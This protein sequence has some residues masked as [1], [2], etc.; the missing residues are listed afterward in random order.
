MMTTSP[1]HW[2]V[3]AAALQTGLT[4]AQPLT[5]AGD[6]AGQVQKSIDRSLEQLKLKPFQVKPLANLDV[7]ALETAEPI[8]KLLGV[9]IQ[10]EYLQRKVQDYWAPTIGQAVSPEDLQNFHV[11]LFEEARRVGFL[12][13][14]ITSARAQGDGSLLQVRVVRPK[15]QSIR[16]ISPS[17]Q[18]LTRYASLVARRLDQDFKPRQP[19]DTLG[20][21]QRLSSASYD[22]PVELEATIR[23]VAPEEIDL[24]VTIHP[25]PLRQGQVLDALVQINNHGLRAFGR[26]QAMVALTLGGQEPKASLSLTA[27]KSEGITYGRA[28]YDLAVH[29]SQS[30]LK[31]WG[32][33]SSSHSI[34][35]TSS[36]SKGE[37][38]EFGLA[39]HRIHSGYRDFVFMQHIEG[40]FRTTENR[41]ASTG[42]VTS[43]LHDNQFRVRLSADNSM[44]TA[45]AS[46]AEW[47]YAVGQYSRADGIELDDIYGKLEL[48]LRHQHIWS[49]D[50][51]WYSVFRFKGQLSSSR[52][53]TYNQLALG[54]NGG[55]RAY[56]GVDGVGDNGAVINLELLHRLSDA[57]V[58]G[59]FYDA[60]VVKL[61][62][63]KMASLEYGRHY[64]LQ[65]LGMQWSAQHQGVVYNSTLAKGFGGHKGWNLY[66][67]ESK[68]NNWRLY[69]SAT[70]RF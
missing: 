61:R 57:S 23:A 17:S 29:E 33:S 10:D 53:D 48:N 52:L 3:L 37:S 7:M 68:P 9:D 16:V 32:T 47:V 14:A 59:A 5:S 40:S 62:N 30:H 60:G 66:N 6:A 39:W 42:T 28:E 65:A 27:Q 13:Y 34:L 21:D 20:L 18:L 26:P 31:V 58:V 11:W 35:S 8:A 67:I 12:S 51:R 4:F 54:G 69:M 64:W 2:L 45:D 38:R 24:V 25:A 70:Y 15:I 22:L 44:V 63:P 1:I 36:A 56:T 55:V 41:L 19:L 46:R 43:A 49:Q 50:R